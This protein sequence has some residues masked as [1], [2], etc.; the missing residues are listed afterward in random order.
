MLNDTQYLKEEYQTETLTSP[1]QSVHNQDNAD[2][3]LY[4]MKEASW[5]LTPEGDKR[6][7]IQPKDL[8]ELWVHTGTLCNLA[9]PFCFEGSSNTSTRIECLSLEEARPLLVEAL[10][11]G[12]KQFSFTGGEPFMN[13]DFVNILDFALDNK[14]CLVLTNAT[15]PLR[16]S[17]DKIEKLKNKAHK[18]SFRVSIDSPDK[19]LHNKNRGEGNF[20]LALENCK[21]LLD[22]GFNVSIAAQMQ[23]LKSNDVLEQEYKALFKNYGLSENTQVVIFPDLLLPCQSPTVPFITE[24]CMTSYKT[25]DERDKFMCS[26]SAM[27]T[28]KKGEIHIY[29]CTLVDDDDDYNM[30]QNLTQ[31]LQ[32]RVMLRHHRCFACFSTGTS[33]SER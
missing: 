24:N 8:Q 13:K 32:Y 22:M 33:C 17:L 9:C 20:E 3:V 26:H 12:V 5:L 4:H 18:L 6:G 23:A 19:D 28:K 7:Y 25:E 16:A 1:S 10:S 2:K 27:I 29:P 30:G 11:L 31:A 15:K 21:K 14:P